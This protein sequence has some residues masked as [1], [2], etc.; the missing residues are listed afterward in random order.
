MDE[1]S[2]ENMG[3]YTKIE[4]WN[5]KEKRYVAIEWKGEIFM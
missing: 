2:R 4:T 3:S 1:I 5:N